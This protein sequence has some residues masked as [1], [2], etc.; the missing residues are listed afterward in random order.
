MIDKDSADGL[1]EQ[2]VKSFDGEAGR[3]LITK[4]CLLANEDAVAS[5]DLASFF[6]IKSPTVSFA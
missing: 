4:D 2:G 3:V 6:G 1:I 5:F